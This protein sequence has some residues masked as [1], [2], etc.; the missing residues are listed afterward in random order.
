SNY[1]RS[2]NEKAEATSEFLKG[3]GAATS[4]CMFIVCA[5]ANHSFGGGWKGTSV[6]VGV[7]SGFSAGTGAAVEVVAPV[8]K[9]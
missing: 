9:F 6:E 8:K 7:G 1:G 4:G 5:G 3:A 2:A